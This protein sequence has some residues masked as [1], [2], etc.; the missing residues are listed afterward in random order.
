VDG[1]STSHV[2]SVTTI[3]APGSS[4]SAGVLTLPATS[5]GGSS[6]QFYNGSNW[7]MPS[8]V[9]HENSSISLDMNAVSPTF[10]AWVLRVSPL[11]SDVV[12]LQTELGGKQNV[13]ANGDVTVTGSLL[14]HSLS[15]VTS[16]T[17]GNGL[18]L[19]AQGDP[20]G[21]ERQALYFQRPAGLGS[22]NH[23]ISVRMDASNDG[24]NYFRHSVNNAAGTAQSVMIVNALREVKSYGSM[25]AVAFTVTSDR[26][27]KANIETVDLTGVFDRVECRSYNRT[28]MV[29]EPR[30]VGFVSQE[31]RDAVTAAGVP[32]NFTSPTT[33]EED[34]RE[35]L[36][37]DLSRLTT[38][39]W[40][41]CK[42][43]EAALAGLTARVAT[44]EAPRTRKRA[45]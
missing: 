4:V 27:V 1:A 18:S 19:R 40:S 14:A 44:L 22:E 45:R 36:G 21:A 9:W 13:A 2:G 33:N 6:L 11:V 20:M 37:L 32:N 29:G 26:S 16:A 39:L 8:K 38:V 31:V 43:Q 42:R 12:N 15:T 7:V 5:S 35:L 10:G 23:R 3:V 41:V 17:L 24:L 30:R 34:G 28:D 25:H